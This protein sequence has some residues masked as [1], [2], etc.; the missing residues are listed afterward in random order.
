MSNHIEDQL[1]AYMDNELSETERQQVEEHL[2]TCTE[3]SE[4]LKD[5]SEIRNQVF[6]VFHSVE[7]PEGFEDKVIHTIGLN[8][9]KGSKWLLV[10][11]ISALCFITLTFVLAGSFLFKLG[12]IMLRVIYNL[13]NV[14]GNILGSNTYI[15]VG[16]VVFSIL[17]IIASSISIKH[18]I[19]T[20][21]FRRANW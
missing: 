17:L 10:P 11:L 5:L 13:I 8:V 16:S 3:C 1:S 14:F 18:L 12:S 4:L 6:N 2:N 15:V 9:S 7:A 20:E 19:K 21:E